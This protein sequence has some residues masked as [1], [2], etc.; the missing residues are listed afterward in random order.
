MKILCAA[1]RRKTDPSECVPNPQHPGCRKCPHAKKREEARRALEKKQDE[2][3]SESVSASCNPPVS[4]EKSAEPLP[5]LLS[6]SEAKP[7]RKRSGTIPKK[8]SQELIN[9]IRA[10]MTC[11]ARLTA[12]CKPNAKQSE[13]L[14]REIKAELTE[15]E[16]LKRQ[17][18][19][20][21]FNIRGESLQTLIHGAQ[22]LLDPEVNHE[23]PNGAL[24]KLLDVDPTIVEERWI[25]QLICKEAFYGHAITVRAVPAEEKDYLL[26]TAVNALAAEPGGMTY[27]EL[28]KQIC[29]AFPGMTIDE[30]NLRRKLREWGV[31]LKPDRR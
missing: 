12:L 10:Q 24:R 21:Y 18:R 9:T 14:K 13:V 6:A 25:Q 20:E 8:V 28:T 11:N 16:R 29:L 31:P 5:V 30:P 17:L 23:R 22:V 15:R 7:S 4:P 19:D 1:K 26:W 3:K 2:K 27:A